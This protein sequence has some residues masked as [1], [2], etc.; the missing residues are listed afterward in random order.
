MERE[1]GRER[2][3]ILCEYKRENCQK[4]V[5]KG[6]TNIISLFVLTLK[7][8]VKTWLKSVPCQVLEDSSWRR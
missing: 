7:K 4:I 2:I 6:C 8:G 5:T 1:K 3:R